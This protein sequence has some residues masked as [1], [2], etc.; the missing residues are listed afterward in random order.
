M[1]IKHEE[2]VIPKDKDSDPFLNCKL[3]RSKYANILTS[4]VSTYSDGFVLAVNNKWGSGK[5][6]FVKMWRQQLI[7]SGFT[8]FY[9]NAWENDFHE[10]VLI[11][12]LAE[13]NLD[14]GKGEQLFKTVLTKALPLL[15]SAVPE[16]VKHTVERKFGDSA[17]SLISGVGDYSVKEL[18]KHLKDFN[19]KKKSIK[20]FRNKL[21]EY[22]K[23]VDDSKPVIFIIDELDR[24]RPNYS[25]EVLEQIK[26]LF[27][28]KGIVF[29]LSIDK[30]QLGNAVK[31]F[32]GSEGI[33]S[34]EYLRR[35]I[36]I[37]YSIPEPDKNAFCNYL[38]DYF[39]F[40]AFFNSSNRQKNHDFNNDSKTFKTISKI[41]FSNRLVILRQIEKIYGHIAIVLKTFS[42]HENVFPISLL[43]LVYCKLNHGFFYNKVVNLSFSLQEL[44]DSME[45]INP[46]SASRENT[47]YQTF[48]M[49]N[50]LCL[51]ANNLKGNSVNGDLLSFQDIGGKAELNVTFN[52][53]NLHEQEIT[54][55]VEGFYNQFKYND[56]SMDTLINKINLSDS[57][58]IEL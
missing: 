56:A 54:R 9:F 29:V 11:A 22:V 39:N 36:D 18:E 37:E 14:K 33:D 4:I 46:V 31:G 26:H 3:G 7:N 28:V 30:F 16:I 47:R 17:A 40:G 45:E 44:V 24:C 6:T 58:T 52:D 43:F 5:T 50:M 34:E 23:L 35:F 15:K 2:L 42:I 49:S 38:Y 25:V 41:L 57:F 27:S 51:Y 32:Y 1:I 13:L 53:Y 8:T 12:L 19:N 21:E 20:E 48:L 10:N 55:S